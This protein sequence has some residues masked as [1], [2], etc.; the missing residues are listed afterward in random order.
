MESTTSPSSKEGQSGGLG[1][2]LSL[3][4]CAERRGPRAQNGQSGSG[5][6]N[7]NHHP[8]TPKS[9]VSSIIPPP[10]DMTELGAYARDSREVSDLFAEWSP[11]IY[12][13]FFSTAPSDWSFVVP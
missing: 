6:A 8:T 5:D 7:G 10:F 4:R 11:W 12:L 3:R 1:R 2:V 13:Y 9:I